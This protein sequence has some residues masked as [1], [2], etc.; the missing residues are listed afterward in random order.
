MTL[1]EALKQSTASAGDVKIAVSVPEANVVAIE[2]DGVLYIRKLSVIDGQ[3]SVPFS[4]RWISADKAD[5][6]NWRPG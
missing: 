5:V 3:N 1:D 4:G 6:F 2:I